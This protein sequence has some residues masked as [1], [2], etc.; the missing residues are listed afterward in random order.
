M[1]IGIIGSSGFLGKNLYNFLIQNT[2]SKIFKFPSFHKHKNKWLSLVVSKIKREKFDILINCSADQKIDK[3]ELNVINQLNSNLLSNILFLMEG[4]KNKNFKGYISFGTK[5]EFGDGK[6]KKPLNFYAATKKA[7]DIFF[8]YFSNKETSI[9]SLKIFDTYG[10]NDRRKKFFNDL[11][12]SYKKNKIL[13]ITAGQQYLD[14]VHINDICL[15]IF[16]IIFDI[17]SKKLKGFK[18]YTVSSKR[19]I[20]LINF[21]KMLNTILKKEIKTKIEKDYR[22]NESFNR[23]KKIF[24]YPGWK[25]KTNFKKELKKIFDGC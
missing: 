8:D 18:Y 10:E 14:Y 7:N 17:K 5:W 16:K 2:K 11:L 25:I 15:L 20:K 9:I 23:I 6:E 24:N 3:N 12:K 22:N 19:P 4:Q 1:K 13:K 21:I